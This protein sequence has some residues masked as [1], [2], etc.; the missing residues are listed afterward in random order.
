MLYFLQNHLFVH[1]E[2][3][4][5]TGGAVKSPGAS[6]YKLFGYAFFI[7]RQILTAGGAFIHE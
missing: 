6:V 7:G 4:G 3:I 2:H 1:F 5:Q